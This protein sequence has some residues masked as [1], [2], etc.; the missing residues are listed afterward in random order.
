MRY[1]LA[2][3]RIVSK[4]EAGAWALEALDERWRPL[5]EAALADRADP[6]ERVRQTAPPEAAAETAAF[7]GAAAQ[8]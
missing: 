6:W 7:A 3:G 8:L 1:T 2:R 4:R 5:I